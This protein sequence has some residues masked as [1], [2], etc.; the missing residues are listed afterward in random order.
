MMTNA[1]VI[2]AITAGS[3]LGLVIGLRHLELRH[4]AA[5]RRVYDVSFSRGLGIESGETFVRGLA[6]LMPPWWR[7]PL[8]L[9]AVVWEITAT[10]ERIGYRVWVEAG[11]ADFVLGQLRAAFPAARITPLPTPDEPVTLAGELRLSRTDRML[12]IER[13]EGISA[14]LLSA[15]RPVDD[16][17]RL[18]VQLVVSPAA[19]PVPASPTPERPHTHQPLPA[20]V[21]SLL[22]PQRPAPRDKS[23][24]D[25]LVGP[26]F[27]VSLRLGVAATSPDR[28][29]QLLRRI[30]GCFHI[31]S[32]SGVRLRRRFL[33]SALVA[34]RI[35]RAATP[36]LEYP[37]LVN[38]RELAALLAVPLGEIL[39]PGLDLSRSRQLPAS[40]ALPPSGPTLAVS[41]YPGSERALTW[42]L[43]SMPYHAW[44]LGGTG[45]G[46]STLLANIVSAYL[47]L[48]A[49][50][51]VLDPMRAIVDTI[52]DLI[53]EQRRH[54]VAIIDPESDSVVGVD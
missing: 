51:L 11:A 26:H 29:R 50:V 48:D 34:A 54:Q 30:N 47:R 8:G 35:C 19:S 37:L 1:L 16:G 28:A 31:V 20:T 14:S 32:G 13:A 52:T 53:P 41:N 38:T 2:I 23:S 12:S 15:L 22:S 18:I 42:G 5:R 7:R 6:G 24:K 27:L 49:A 44:I 9:P 10:P 33:P 39:V 40:V 36:L 46:K 21:L 45:N 25:K 4:R 17:E 43:S 3:G